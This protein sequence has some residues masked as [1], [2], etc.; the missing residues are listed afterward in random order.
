MLENPVMAGGG[1]GG[2]LYGEAVRSRAWNQMIHI[3]LLFLNRILYFSLSAKSYCKVN[4]EV[5]V[6]PHSFHSPFS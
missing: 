6:D 3:S 2:V 4:T 1:D 5:E